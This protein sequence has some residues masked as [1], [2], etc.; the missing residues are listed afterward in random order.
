MSSCR[1]SHLLFLEGL[2][3]SNLEI[4]SI[5]ISWGAFL[6]ELINFA[7]IAFAVFIIAKKVLKEE[8]V[9]KK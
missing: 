6:A 1:L 4:G 9:E 8:K 2:G 7:I 5:V 3:D